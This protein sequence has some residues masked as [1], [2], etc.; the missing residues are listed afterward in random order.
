MKKYRVFIMNYKKHVTFTENGKQYTRR[1]YKE[2]DNT[3]YII[4]N[5]EKVTVTENELYLF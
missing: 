1:L 3:Y 4:F 2:D 5:Y